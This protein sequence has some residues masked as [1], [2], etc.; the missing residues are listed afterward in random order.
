MIC[1]KAT[2]QPSDSGFQNMVAFTAR[3]GEILR[4]ASSFLDLCNKKLVGF[5]ITIL[6]NYYK[7]PLSG[8][9]SLVIES[10]I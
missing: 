8:H 6:N 10:L 5:L 3:I 4:K 1:H 2:G 7:I 9:S